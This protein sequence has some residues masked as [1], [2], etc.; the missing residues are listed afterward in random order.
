[1]LNLENNLSDG[2]D[3]EDAESSPVTPHTPSEGFSSSE[4]VVPETVTAP[5]IYN[6][7]SNEMTDLHGDVVG[8]LEKFVLEPAS[9][10]FQFKCRIT[11]DRK[12][13]D[14]GLYPTYF[15]HLE[16]DCSKKIFLLAGRKRKKSTTSN[17]LI[18]TDPTDL[19]RGGEAFVGKLRSNLLGTH[20]TVYDNGTSPR[21]LGS[22]DHLAPPRQEL[23]A[24]VYDTNVL[25]F[26]GPRKM[27]VILPGMTANNQRISI[28]PTDDTESL[29][30]CFRTKCMD[31]LIQLHNKTPAWNDDTQ[32]YVL[33]FHGRVT[34]ASVKNFQIVHDSDGKITENGKPLRLSKRPNCWCLNGSVT[35]CARILGVSRG[36]VSKV[37]TAFEREG[38]RPQPSTGLVESR[39]CL[40]ETVGL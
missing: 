37:M 4:V 8:N 5:F 14:R 2:L 21:H 39:S 17:Y 32:S 10:H 35:E 7:T 22:K 33:N 29:L 25:G 40:R 26:K 38:K 34:Q 15:L 6:A 28:T 11:R 20:F 16:R 19:S 24:I 30:E 27:T 13:M 31:N 12:G 3:V 23:A 36:N 1:M 9:Q 18:S